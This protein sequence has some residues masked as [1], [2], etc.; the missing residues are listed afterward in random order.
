[1]CWKKSDRLH[2]FSWEPA[3]ANEFVLSCLW[4]TCCWLC[5]VWSSVTDQGSFD[6]LQIQFLQCDCFLQVTKLPTFPEADAK[7]K[8]FPSL[9]TIQHECACMLCKMKQWSEKARR[10][11]CVAWFV[12]EIWAKNECK[13]K[14]LLNW[15][16]HFIKNK[17][18][19]SVVQCN[20]NIKIYIYC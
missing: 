3:N 10:K 4:S 18:F 5:I 1:M 13:K 12:K 19:F 8:S 14:V 6:F 17:K 16:T 7:C 2:L 20:V 11:L 15:M 9:H